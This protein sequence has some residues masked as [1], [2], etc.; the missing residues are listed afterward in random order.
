MRQLKSILALLTV[1]VSISTGLAQV[2]TTFE[3]RV[4]N[5]TTSLSNRIEALE[6]QLNPAAA[7]AR[8][9]AGLLRK[10]AFST[11]TGWT[12]SGTSFSSVASPSLHSWGNYGDLLAPGA[13]GSLDY[14]GIREGTLYTEVIDSVEK[15]FFFYD[16][17]NGTNT[18]DGEWRI[19]LATSVN[20]GLTWTRLGPINIGLQTGESPAPVARAIL[21]LEKHG[22][23]YYLHSLKSLS[24]SGVSSRGRIPF[25]PYVSDVWELPVTSA[26]PVGN[27]TYLRKS[28]EQGADNTTND[29]HSAYFSSIQWDAEN[30]VWRSFYNATRVG[31]PYYLNVGVATSLY[32]EGPYNK[33]GVALGN[34]INTFVPE[35]PKVFYHP[36]FKKWVMTL[37]EGTHQLGTT[38]QNTYLFSEH[39]H[40]GWNVGNRKTI[41]RA[42]TLDGTT[43]IGI[44]SPFFSADAQVA[45]IT[46]DGCVP[47]YYDAYPI[48]ATWPDIHAGRKQ[49]FTVLEPSTNRFVYAPIVSTSSFS[50][51]FSFGGGAINGSNGWTTVSSAGGVPSYSSNRLDLGSTIGGSLIVNNGTSA[52]NPVMTADLTIGVQAAVGFVFRYQ[53]ASNYY[54]VDVSRFSGRFINASLVKVQGG[55]ETNISD[56]TA[57]LGEVAEGAAARTNVTVNGNRVT[58]RLAGGQPVTFFDLDNTFTTAGR[59]GLRGGFPANASRIVDDYNV[60][61]STPTAGADDIYT[62]VSNGN[63]TAEYTIDMDTMDAAGAYMAFNFRTAAGST[64]G[65]RLK[66]FQN[67]RLQLFKVAGGVETSLASQSGT[68]LATQNHPCRIKVVANGTSIA[69]YLNG[70]QQVAVTDATY[71]NGTR[72]GFTA[73]NSRLAVPYFHLYAS[74][75]VTITGLTAGQVV[76]LRAAG[77]IPVASATATGSSIQLTSFHYPLHIIDVNGVDYT[78][79]GGVWGGDTLNIQ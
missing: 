55:V 74:N 14:G 66:C 37:N 63:F 50:D 57:A 33:A 59:C 65:Y 35:N 20:R 75:A 15:W 39:L 29:D 5:A 16:A 24:A 42:S 44:F 26:G 4:V 43:A 67:G 12:Q 53:D 18:T 28:L 79:T 70:E 31:T 36:L 34:D 46:A 30:S 72:T 48:S 41:H 2:P 8:T 71:L 52:L 9:A 47:G 61:I 56:Q 11:L 45:G 54:F 76:T 40:T 64:N 58:V 10:E 3:Q 78:P 69:A 7:I 73:Y 25:A 19:N 13:S 1:L 6:V 38:N 49:V 77:G 21:L 51:N 23:R 62:N 32:P 17:G 22:D 68:Q 27:W 60:V